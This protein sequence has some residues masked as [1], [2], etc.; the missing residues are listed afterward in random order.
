MWIEILIALVAILTTA[1]IYTILPFLTT[2]SDLAP[3]YPDGTNWFTWSIGNLPYFMRH[4]RTKT[5]HKILSTFADHG[6][7]LGLK[8][9]VV[10]FDIP[11]LSRRGYIVSDAA[12]GN[13]LF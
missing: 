1:F 9:N 5:F 7:S 4:Q 6:R 13:R 10:R 3:L 2:S 11:I 8:Q 12:L